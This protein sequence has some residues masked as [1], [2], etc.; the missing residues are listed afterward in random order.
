[1]EC[2][3]RDLQKI[4]L[5]QDR[6]TLVKYIKQLPKKGIYKIPKV[7]GEKSTSFLIDLDQLMSFDNWNIGFWD[8][9]ELWDGNTCVHYFPHYYMFKSNKISHTPPLILMGGVVNTSEHD[10]KCIVSRIAKPT[11]HNSPSWSTIKIVCSMVWR[12]GT[13][14]AGEISSD[15]KIKRSSVINAIRKLP[16]GMIWK[17]AKQGRT[18]SYCLDLE[19][20]GDHVD[21]LREEHGESAR[22][23]LLTQRIEHERLWN[24][25]I[26]KLMAAYVDG[27][28][29]SSVPL[30]EGIPPEEADEFIEFKLPHMVQRKR[31]SE[32][33]KQARKEALLEE[34]NTRSQWEAS[35]ISV[36]ERYL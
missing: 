3:Q 30:P 33:S 26:G 34:G 15:C 32:R 31:E 18:Q 23:S 35:L 16:E 9:N 27:R 20:V 10:F 6:K 19:K 25:Y 22:R 14:T 4:F 11:F 21:S 1:M 7:K 17:G 28:G 36:D 24:P 2:P 12:G 8:V 5:A 13:A 29:M